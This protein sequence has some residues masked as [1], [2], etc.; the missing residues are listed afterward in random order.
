MSN[1]FYNSY[2]K[3][4]KFVINKIFIEFIIFKFYIILNIKVSIKMSKAGDGG[5]DGGAINKV[6]LDTEKGFTEK[7]GLELKNLLYGIVF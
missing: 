4:L 5:A 3:N 6:S 1:N 7:L 2:L